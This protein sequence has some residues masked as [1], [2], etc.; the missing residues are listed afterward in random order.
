MFNHR[1]AAHLSTVYRKW[2]EVYKKINMVSKVKYGGGLLW[3]GVL[4]L[5]LIYLASSH[6][7]PNLH[8]TN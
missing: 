4:I 6:C 8:M 7:V 1:V 3:F 2:N 5:L